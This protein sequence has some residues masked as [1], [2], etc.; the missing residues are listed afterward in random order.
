MQ[1]VDLADKAWGQVYT[2]SISISSCSSTQRRDVKH[3]KVRER[4]QAGCGEFPAY[5]C[6]VTYHLSWFLMDLAD[7]NR[8]SHIRLHQLI[9]CRERIEILARPEENLSP[10][11]SILSGPRKM[12]RP[13]SPDTDEVPAPNDQVRF[14]M[15]TLSLLSLWI[16]LTQPRLYCRL[17]IAN[18]SLP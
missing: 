13:V 11:K 8:L 17:D 6:S 2:D 4:N 18:R 5:S 3:A 9:R 1:S 10:T 7:R 12:P 16:R 14:E 15:A